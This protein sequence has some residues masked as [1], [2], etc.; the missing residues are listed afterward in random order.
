MF[1]FF[2]KPEPVIIHE[3]PNY[4]KV[5]AITAVTVAVVEAIVIFAVLIIKKAR[6]AKLA[7][8][9][10]TLD[11]GFETIANVDEV[12]VEFES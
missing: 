12:H 9:A 8:S 7:D 1:E 2:K 3:K 6:D 5:I 11:D 4:G 10:N